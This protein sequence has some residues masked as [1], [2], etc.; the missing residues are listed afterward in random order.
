MQKLIVLVYFADRFCFESIRANKALPPAHWPGDWRCVERKRFFNFIEQFK[1]IAAVTIKLIDKGNDRDVSQTTDFKEL[2]RA[3]LYAFS[4]VNH[5]DGRIHSRKG[6]I[7]VFG[8][9]LMAWRIKQIEYAI[10]IFK[11]HD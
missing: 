9:V 2:T 3:R 6:A 11:G 5:H 10:C 8:K 4:G 1:R 7:G